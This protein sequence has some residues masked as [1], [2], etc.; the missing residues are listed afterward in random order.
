MLGVPD[1]HAIRTMYRR[2][3]SKRQIAKA[4]GVSRTTV[5]RYTAADYVVPSVT[6]MRIARR[7]PVP[8]MDAWKA[9][10]NEWLAADESGPRKQRRTARKIYK[11]LKRLHEA[12]V[13]EVSVRRYV[14]AC[15]QERAKRAYVPLEFGMGEMV[16]VDFGEVRARIAGVEMLIYFV[17]MR[18][19]ASGVSFAKAYPHAK[20]EAWLDGISSGLSFFGGVPVKGMF[21]NA[22]T[23]VRQ[24]LGNGERVQTPEFRA[25]A[26]HYGLEVVF[27]NRGAGNEKGGVEKAVFWA[28]RNL[29]SPVPDAVSL[30]VL[31][32][33]LAAQ[34]LEDAGSRRRGPHGPLVRDLWEEEQKHLAPLPGAAFVA[35][36]R[37]FA[38]VDKTLLCMYDG[39]KYSAP[40]GYAGQALTLRAFWDRIELADRERTVAVH[41]PCLP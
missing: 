5:D 38:P 2:D 26:A 13:S 34:C 40:A 36:R 6:E 35:C 30:E 22:S 16:E 18:L 8:K 27:A 7:R 1:I 12:G 20:L 3:I 31:N 14:A 21:D 39:A 4:L 11:D 25:L 9:I 23:L 24:I 15:K 29:F 28:E 33:R 10:I 17:A 37:R 19:M 41:E 32:E